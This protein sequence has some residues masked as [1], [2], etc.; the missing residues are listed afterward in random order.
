MTRLNNGR[1]SHSRDNF[2]H[3]G[4]F[5]ISNSAFPLKGTNPFKGKKLL[6]LDPGNS[7]YTRMTLERTSKKEA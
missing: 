1:F 2:L 4:N 3:R 6:V 7:P 5:H